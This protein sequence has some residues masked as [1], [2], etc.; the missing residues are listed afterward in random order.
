[1][2]IDKLYK[3]DATIGSK[4]S[5]QTNLTIT[6]RIEGFIL[7]NGVYAWGIDMSFLWDQLQRSNEGP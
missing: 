7:G 1:M 4:E 6:F 3:S 5:T 2:D